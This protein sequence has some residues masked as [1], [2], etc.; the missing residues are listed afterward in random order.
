M[1]H[2]IAKHAPDLGAGN[3]RE[4]VFLGAEGAVRLASGCVHEVSP[5]AAITCVSCSSGWCPVLVQVLTFRA[6]KR[7]LEEYGYS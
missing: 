1:L 5:R 6:F 7:P 4:V 3:L 2:H